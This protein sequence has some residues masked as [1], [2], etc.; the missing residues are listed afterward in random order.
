MNSI[1]KNHNSLVPT[2]TAIRAVKR[3]AQAY[4]VNVQF[5]SVLFGHS[6]LF[7]GTEPHHFSRVEEALELIIEVYEARMKDSQRDADDASNDYGYSDDE[8]LVKRLRMTRGEVWRS[9]LVIVDGKGIDTVSV[10][11]DV[12]DPKEV[13][14]SFSGEQNMDNRVGDATKYLIERAEGRSDKQQDE[15]SL[16]AFL[17]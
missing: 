8:D 4:G 10:L 3:L 17:R 5:D 11:V 6:T 2:Y 16:P 15:E 9:G 12:E 13:Y 1:D 14:L 7:I